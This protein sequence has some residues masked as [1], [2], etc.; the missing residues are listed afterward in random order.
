[1][2]SSPSRQLMTIQLTFSATASATRHAPS[3]AKTTDLRFGAGDHVARMP[4]G[5][6]LGVGS[7][8]CYS[9]ARVTLRASRELH[10]CLGCLSALAALLAL[11]VDHADAVGHA[12]AARSRRIWIQVR[13][14]SYQARP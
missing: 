5:K 1:M 13:S 14:N 11:D 12:E 10:A 3:V 4:H 6:W 2:S 9:E 7:A 8:K